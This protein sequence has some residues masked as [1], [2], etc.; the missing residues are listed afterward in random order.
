M[1][2]EKP[3]YSF[4]GLKR[5]LA[6]MGY[7]VEKAVGYRPVKN[8]DVDL[9]DLKNNIEFTDDGIFL[10]D[11]ADGSRQQIFL[12]KRNYHLE[13]FGKPRFHIR[14]C[15][16]IQS[17]I[18]SGSFKKEYRR[19]NTETVMVCD[20]DD[21]YTDKEI[22]ALPLCKFCAKMV[23]DIPGNS[24]SSDFVEILKSATD[25]TDEHGTNQDVE[26]DIFGYTKDWESISQAYRE[27]KEYRCERCGIKIDDP[28]DRQYIH[29]HHKNGIK[30]DNRTGN[31]ECLCIRC[32][33]KTDEHHMYNFSRGANLQMLKEFEDKYLQ[34]P[35]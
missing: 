6:E 17:F 11:P 19:A 4:D 18:A 33:A 30:T 5:K 29:V 7:T 35:F 10:I 15:E 13:R 16:T 12:Y 31:L 21:N 24:D 20:M 2:E 3:I 9:N 26:V 8:V 28:F 14:K 34:L 1:K 27:L 25:A 23:S 32:H 22:S